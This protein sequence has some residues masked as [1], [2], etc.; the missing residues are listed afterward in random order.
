M[1]FTTV[2]T[3]LEIWRGNKQEE[4]NT[5]ISFTVFFVQC[6]RIEQSEEC[7]GVKNVAY[8]S[9]FFFFHPC[10]P[11]LSLCLSVCLSVSLF[12]SLFVLGYLFLSFSVCLFVC[13]Y[14]CVCVCVCM[15]VCVHAHIHAHMHMRM[16]VCVCV[17]E[18]VCVCVCM[19]AFFLFVP[20][21]IFSS[22]CTGV[23]VCGYS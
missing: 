21:L 8:A 5:L 7:K 22:L 23:R 18:Y 20:G 13:V 16:C 3:S 10:T 14:V 4:E 2:V 6:M 9:L 11:T 1:N 17:Y 19:R 15:C 12:Q